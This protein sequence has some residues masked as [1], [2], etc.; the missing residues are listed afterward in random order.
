MPIELPLAHLHRKAQE[1]GAGKSPMLV[2][3][4]GYGSNE[5]DLFG[6][7]DYLDPRFIVV[8]LRAP[9]TVQTGAYAWYHVHWTPDGRARGD[10]SL[11]GESLDK[12]RDAVSVAIAAYD[13]NPARVFLAGFSQGAMMSQALALTQ[14]ALVAGAVLMSGRTLQ[15]LREAQLSVDQT[16]PPMFVTHGVADAVVPVSE[17]H[18][19]RDFLNALNATCEYREYPMAHTISEQSI[20]DVDA[21]LTARLDSV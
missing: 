9:L 4:H 5:A 17:G 13:A 2:L 3:A 10:E 14:P 11:A 6:L 18:A 12:Y 16:Y 21:W 15:M 19:T 7:I 1:P 8:S 20:A